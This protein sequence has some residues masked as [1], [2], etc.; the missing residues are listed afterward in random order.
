M[1]LTKR[2]EQFMQHTIKLALESEAEGNMPFG[3]VIVLDGKVIAEGRNRVF[4]PKLNPGAHA[5]IEALN[6]VDWQSLLGREKELVLYT[7]IEPCIMCFSTIVLHHIGKVV[8]GGND[9]NKGAA[10]LIDKLDK[11]YKREQLPVFIGPVKQDKCL[12]M[13]ERAHEVYS[14]FW[15]NTKPVP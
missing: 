11:I 6:K 12:P 7:N 10:Y 13:W 15:D 4:Y 3:A 5:E 9:T 8:F 1:K 2:E 14:N